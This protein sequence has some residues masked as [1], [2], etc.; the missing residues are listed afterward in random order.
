M[1][2]GELPPHF[3]DDIA[4]AAAAG[5]RLLLVFHQDGC[6]YCNALVERNLS[7]K[8]IEQKVRKHFDVVAINMWGDRDVLTVG[9]EQYTEKTFAAALKVQFTPTLIFSTS[10]ARW[11]CA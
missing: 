1:V 11:S 9:G 8:D 10:R 3:E 7:Q 2:Q 6:P 4:E 5:K